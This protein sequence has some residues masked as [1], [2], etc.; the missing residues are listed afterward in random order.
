LIGRFALGGKFKTSGLNSV[1]IKFG[2]NGDITR[3]DYGAGFRA[4]FIFSKRW[5]A[6]LGY[7]MG[8]NNL[9][10]TP[11]APPDGDKGHTRNFSLSL[12]LWLK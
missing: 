10:G 5:D 11:G 6:T 8:L 9:L 1:A 2:K 4:G 7:D 3:M 12:G